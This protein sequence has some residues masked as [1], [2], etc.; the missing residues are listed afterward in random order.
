[1]G[2]IE[3]ITG[4]VKSGVSSVL[5]AGETALAGLSTTS[6]AVGSAVAGGVIGAGGTALVASAVSK[7][8]SKSSRKTSR[9]GRARDRRFKSKQKHERKYKRK[10]KYKVYGRKGYINPKR[11][12]SKSN[13]RR[14]GVHYTKKGQPYILLRSGK[15]RFIKQRGKK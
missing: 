15:A 10:R 3:D 11:K 8:K 6:L 12:K 13:S 4:G 14:K 5:S 1:M 9:S 7:K 2:L